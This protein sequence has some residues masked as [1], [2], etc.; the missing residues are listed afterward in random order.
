MYI[1]QTKKYS[2]EITE[3][4]QAFITFGTPEK[5]IMDGEDITSEITKKYGCVFAWLRRLCVA[6]NNFNI[7]AF[8]ITRINGSVKLYI[9]T[10]TITKDLIFD[11]EHYSVD[12]KGIIHKKDG[13]L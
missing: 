4:A 9:K 8:T 11:G 3:G 2:E 10:A 7:K 6:F 12:I 13:G 1:N 5:I